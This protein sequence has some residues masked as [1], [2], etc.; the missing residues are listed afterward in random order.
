MAVVATETINMVSGGADLPNSAH[1]NPSTTP[2]IGLM[3]NTACQFDGTKELEYATGVT[4]NQIWARNG[5]V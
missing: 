2:A 3:A 4:N 1:L 5:I